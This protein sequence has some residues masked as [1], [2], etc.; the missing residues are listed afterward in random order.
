MSVHIYMHTYIYAKRVNEKV[1]K[2]PKESKKVYGK[3]WRE[4]GWDG[5]MK[6]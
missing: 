3:V 1:V 2:D 5:K 6:L 4:G